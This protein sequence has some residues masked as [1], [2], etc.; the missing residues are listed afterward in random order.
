MQKGIGIVGAI[1]L[2]GLF[3]ILQMI[4]IVVTSIILGHILNKSISLIIALILSYCIVLFI[5]YKKYKIRLSTMQLQ[6]Q[7]NNFFIYLIF[8]LALFVVMVYIKQPYALGEFSAHTTSITG[9]SWNELLDSYINNYEIISDILYVFGLTIILPIFEELLFRGI[10]FKGLSIKYN[11]L[12]AIIIV[13]ILFALLHSFTDEMWFLGTFFSGIMFT[14]VLLKTESMF[15]CILLHVIN[16][17]MSYFSSLFVKIY[18][19]NNFVRINDQKILFN[20]IIIIISISI[21]ILMIIYL[22]YTFVYKR[23]SQ[24]RRTES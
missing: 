23:L 16:N 4:V 17:T 22:S 21:V 15:F 3:F 9:I 19:M 24:I 6:L 10:L 8:G 13:N 20:P 1:G 7:G 2:I 18:P 11:I 5:S 14:I 12:T